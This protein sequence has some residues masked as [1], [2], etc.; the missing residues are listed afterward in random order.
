M[1]VLNS[2][3]LVPTWRGFQLLL[4]TVVATAG[5]FARTV[6]SPLQETIRIAL[7]LSDNQ[8][9][10]L[11][12]PALVIPLLMATVPLGLAVDR[13]SR[14]RLLLVATLVDMGATIT[15]ALAPSFTILFAARCLIGLAAPAT[16]VAAYSL[17]ADYYDEA[18]R[19]R[20]TMVV[21]IGQVGGSSAA[22]A[23]GGALLAMFGSA[24][25]TWRM[26]MLWMGGLLAPVVLLT[27]LLLEPKRV[28][29]AIENPS[30]R[31]IWPE[32][33]HHR[34]AI[35][36]LLAGMSM[37][38]LADGAALVW[39]APTFARN[40]ALPPGQVGA[41]M[42]MVLMSAGILGPIVGGT[43]A[44]F[45][46]RTGGPQR[47]VL[48]LSILAL[49]SA[50]AGLFAVMP[51]VAWA[52]LAL[53]TF[54]MIG[55]AIFVMVIALTI[56]VIPNELR[57]I[58]ITLQMAAGALFGFGLA[59]VSVSLLSGAIGGPAMIGIA[60]AIVCAA[61]TV[62]GAATFVWQWILLRKSTRSV[63]TGS[64]DAIEKVA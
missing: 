53:A 21:N 20:A 52:G 34:W 55:C 6:L 16:A 31:D 35:L 14:V 29:R 33:W 37:V 36:T 3:R 57:G 62:L 60:L 19:G 49:L 10:L 43:L 26:S 56:V 30:M 46:Q 63:V 51:G 42:A 2:L 32:L 23:L 28:G 50:P 4:L 47:T 27:L 41:I 15:A 18:Q 54:V 59:P 64:G 61:V 22:F 40:F 12:G 8:M 38:N 17:L 9:A 24:P 11:Q 1:P 58:C 39:A 25:D 13:Y 7:S 44:D 5:L 48:V 45:C